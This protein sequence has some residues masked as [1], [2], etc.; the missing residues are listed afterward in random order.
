MKSNRYISPHVAEDLRSKLVFVGG[1][2]QVGKTT[3]AKSLLTQAGLSQESAY[4][5]WD[6]AEQQC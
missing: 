2:R 1:P 4:R 5:N 3:L 6:F